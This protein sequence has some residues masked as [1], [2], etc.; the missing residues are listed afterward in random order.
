MDSGELEPCKAL[1][2]GCGKG[3]EAI[4]LGKEF[5]VNGIGISREAVEMTREKAKSANISALG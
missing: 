3:T 4:Y 2:I 1:D 5:A